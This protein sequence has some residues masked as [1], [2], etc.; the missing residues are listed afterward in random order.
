MGVRPLGN[1][2]KFFHDMRRRRAIGIAHAEINNIFAAPARS[3]FQFSSNI[4]NVRGETIDTR[5]TAFRTGFS[6]R[7]L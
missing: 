1:G 2:A 5:K 3:H 7:F 6:H 4:K